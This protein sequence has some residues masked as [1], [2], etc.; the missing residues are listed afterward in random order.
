MIARWTIS[1]VYNK[2]IVITKYNF[3]KSNFNLELTFLRHTHLNYK[4]KFISPEITANKN[5]FYYVS[6]KKHRALN[7]FKLLKS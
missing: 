7:L 1:M 4:T 3:F 6:Y 5:R 2:R